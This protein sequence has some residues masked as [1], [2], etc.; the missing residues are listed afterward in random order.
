M[1]AFDPFASLDG[2][3]ANINNA[4]I[5]IPWK[6]SSAGSVRRPR[7]LRSTTSPC[8]ASRA[9]GSSALGSAWAIEPHTVPRLR[10]WKCE[11]CGKAWASSGTSAASRGRHSTL[12]WVA[13]APIARCLPSF[14]T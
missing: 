8:N 9:S 14:V 1:Y 13:A 4:V 10:I 7:R 12:A 2:D 11:M 3:T 6:K 5:S